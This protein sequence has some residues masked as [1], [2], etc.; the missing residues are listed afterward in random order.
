M[1]TFQ[2]SGRSLYDMV[3]NL[4]ADGNAVKTAEV[5]QK[6]CPMLQDAPVVTANNI[7]THKISVRTGLPSA[8]VKRLNQGVGGSFGS[9]ETY[10]FGMKEY[11]SLPWI[12]KLEFKYAKDPNEVR[13][14]NMEGILQGWGQSI[15]ADFLYDKK[16]N[17]LDSING[18]DS[19]CG[20][21][22][23]NR[24]IDGGA[25]TVVSKKVM[26][27]YLVA[28]DTE[29][30][31]FAIAPQGDTAGVKFSVLGDHVISDP[32]DA[33]KKLLVE[34]YEVDA[35][36][37]F[38]VK[39]KRAIARIANIDCTTVSNT[40]FN[41][42]WLMKAI[43]QFPTWLRNKIVIYVPHE[44]ELAMQ[45]AANV[46]SNASFVYGQKELYAETLSTFNGLPI[47]VSEAIVPQTAIVA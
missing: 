26:S 41:P 5:L 16:S 36:L 11:Q 34:Q 45:M 9:R 44:V 43:N 23:G 7:T 39:D 6:A 15:E 10:E 14:S 2:T 29:M 8:E 3:K 13:Q 42:E 22:E 4:D 20:T 24:V 32:N 21:L 35:S 12:D 47:R 1:A 27:V 19:Y 40:T 30:G 18:I 38:G 33:T 31:A 37:G 28:W 46:K 25:S 17:G